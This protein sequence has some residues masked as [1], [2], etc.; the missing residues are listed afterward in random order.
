[1]VC[2]IGSDLS[3]PKAYVLTDRFQK[4]DYQQKKNLVEWAGELLLVIIFVAEFDDDDP[5]GDELIVYTASKFE[6]YKLDIDDYTC[7]YHEIGIPG[8]RDMGVFDMENE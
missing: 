7:G 1:M 8:G 4:A 2:D 3:P 5:V 6:V